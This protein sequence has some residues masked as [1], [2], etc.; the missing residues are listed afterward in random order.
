MPWYINCAD[1]RDSS[2]PQGRT[3]RQV[4]AEKANTIPIGTLVEIVETGVRMF[5]V[6]YGRDCDQ[7]PLYYLSDDDEDTVPER[8]GW[9]NPGWAGGYGEDSLKVIERAA[10]DTGR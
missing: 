8:E 9:R 2:D 5:V 10:E 4:N 1:L 6:H 3:Y 7:T